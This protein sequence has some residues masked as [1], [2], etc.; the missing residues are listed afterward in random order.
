MIEVNFLNEVCVVSFS[1]YQKGDGTAIQLYVKETGEP[2]A[3]ATVNLVGH[4]NLATRKQFLAN[5]S[6]EHVCV[7]SYDQNEGLLEILQ[8]AGILGPHACYV[9]SG[10]ARYPLCPLLIDREKYIQESQ[11][12]N[13]A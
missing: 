5:G 2:M 3:T 7:K 9:S 1:R 12:A 4:P 11:T 6:L 10:F 8:K 13:A